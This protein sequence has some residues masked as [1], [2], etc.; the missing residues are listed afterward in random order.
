MN[1]FL[2]CVFVFFVFLFLQQLVFFFFLQNDGTH[3]YR[4]A[5]PDEEAQCQLLV[6][7]VLCL[8][9]VSKI[10]LLSKSEVQKKTHNFLCNLC[11]FC[12]LFFGGW[13]VLLFVC[14]N[15]TKNTKR[16]G[17]KG[18]EEEHE[19]LHVLEF[20]SNQKQVSVLVRECKVFFWFTSLP[21]LMWQ[22]HTHKY[23]FAFFFLFF[24]KE[25]T[26]GAFHQNSWWC[27]F[28]F[29]EKKSR[30]TTTSHSIG[31]HFSR[32]WKIF[33]FW[34]ENVVCC[35]SSCESR[36]V[37]FLVWF[38]FC[39]FFVF[40]ITIDF[41]VCGCVFVCL[42]F[43][44]QKVEA[45]FCSFSWGISRSQWG[46]GQQGTKD[47][48]PVPKIWKW[49]HVVVHHRNWGSGSIIFFFFVSCGDIDWWTILTAFSSFDLFLFLIFKITKDKLQD[50]VPETISDLQQAGIRFW[51]LRR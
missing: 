12:C 14:C 25:T 43:Q 26:F 6:S 2:W 42:F 36:F 3:E 23:Y 13:I 20:S 48:T 44:R 31:Y 38:F 1:L 41:C 18:E 10:R 22:V 15:K 39:S 4:S 45:F 17:K 51:M 49:P 5:S 32:S 34:F 11:F 37:R 29:V 35:F 33:F 8:S 28:A 16:K 9:H 46:F 24:S 7:L 21:F 40:P 27:D 19:I 30:T 47:S 50:Q